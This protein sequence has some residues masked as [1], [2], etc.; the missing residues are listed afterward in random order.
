MKAI[1]VHDFGGP[2]VLK[3]ED[4]PDPAAGPGQVVVGIRAVGVNP[5]ETYIRSGSYHVKPDRPYT[6]GLESS[7][8]IESVGEGVT[9]FKTGDRVYTSSS[10]SG[11][12]AEKT[13]CAADSVYP[14]PDR[15]SFEQGAAVDVAYSTSYHALFQRT[16]VFP[17]ETVFI[18][19]ASG[20]V[21]I[22]AVQFARNAGMKVIGTGG[23]E[24]GRA[25]V[26]EQG[27]HHVLDHTAPDYFA[28][29][30]ELTGGRGA[31]VIVEMLAN[32]NLAKDLTAVARDGR[33]L[34]IGNRGTIEINPRDAMVRRAQIIGVLLSLAT[35]EEKKSLRAAIHAGLENGTLNPVV[36]RTFSLSDAFKAHQRVMEPGALGKI[37]LVR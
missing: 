12:Y 32:V 14:L 17:G 33:I 30:M 20:G 7:G 15:V 23:T 11:T 5:M 22:A 36:G 4:V 13:L 9:S 18:N 34:V 8:V 28:R 6:P 2:D 10:L 1:R 3:I 24:N 29:F 25:L 37:I 35:V 19:G 31:D 27:A 16:R 21:G 26:A